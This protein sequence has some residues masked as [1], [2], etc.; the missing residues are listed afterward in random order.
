[1]IVDEVYHKICHR[2]EHPKEDSYTNYLLELGEDKILS[3][4]NNEVMEIILAS[5][6]NIATDLKFEI[7]D[8]LYLLMVLMVEKG[9][10]WED[11]SS[12]LAHRE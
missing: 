11:V 2:K 6:N 10:T 7:S 12:E 9:V 8:L 4:I 5:K 1:M 3:K